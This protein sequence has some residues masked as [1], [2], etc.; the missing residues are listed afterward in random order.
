MSGIEKFF[1]IFSKKKKTDQVGFDVRKNKNGEVVTQEPSQV[2]QDIIPDLNIPK[3][4]FIY[5]RVHQ[6]IPDAD[7]GGLFSTPENKPIGIVIHHTATYNTAD[8]ISIF[9]KNAVDVHFIVGHRGEMIQ[10]VPCNRKAAHAGESSWKGKSSLN[11]YYIGIEVVNIG[12]LT[13]DGSNYL[14]YYNRKKKKEGKPYSYWRGEVRERKSNGEM[15]WE[16]FTPAQEQ[17]ITE[18]CLWAIDSFGIDI[19]NIIGHYECSPGR[20]VDPAGGFSH[21]PVFAYRNYLDKL[22]KQR[23]S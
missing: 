21:G 17:A 19:D 1:S 14:D 13:K 20:K 3:D 7:M 12:Q 4:P 18:I 11:N 23:A 6:Y 5:P 16:P 15:Y 2:R 10:M 9:K 8:T 22:I